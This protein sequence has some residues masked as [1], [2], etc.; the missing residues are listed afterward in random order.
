V[1]FS[2]GSRLWLLA[3]PVALAA[4]Y[5]VGQR[6]RPRDAAAFV[7]SALLGSVV[8]HHP[9]RRRHAA[10]AGIV[11]GA[12][13]AVVAFAGPTHAAEAERPGA[14]VVL[15]LDVSPSMAANDVVPTRIR[16]AQAAAVR[17]TKTLPRRFS[18]GLVTFGGNAHVDALPSTDHRGVLRA[19]AHLELEPR[20][21]IGEAIFASLDAIKNADAAAH[22][23][24]G[25]RPTA[26]IVL[27]S[28]G[29]T[30]SGRSNDDA[31]TAAVRSRVPVSTIAFGTNGAG[32][33]IFGDTIYV[34]PNTEA[35]RQIALATGGHFSDATDVATL[36][37]AYARLENAIVHVTR[38]HALTSWFVG[39]AA[40]SL[41][42]A[43]AAALLWT[44]RLA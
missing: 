43:G 8:P 17:F 35:L 7:S 4:A 12:A 5:V 11:V 28:D 15:A 39:A 6:R 31:A 41:L 20:T 33:D 26:R 36:R 30:N 29:D 40:G 2:A 27:L 42:L 37:R 24:R 32:V 34:A 14:T 23:Q 9:G 21:A 19:L 22:I 1:T 38:Q 44:S 3:L 10:A 16:A 18:L 13:L 25:P